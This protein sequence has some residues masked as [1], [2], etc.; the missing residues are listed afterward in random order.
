MRAS[1]DGEMR[2]VW[3][4][5]HPR[6]SSLTLMLVRGRQRKVL[7]GGAVVML[8]VREAAFGCSEEKGLRHDN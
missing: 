6:L 8:E 7:A 1:L 5:L 3:K 2:L 4:V